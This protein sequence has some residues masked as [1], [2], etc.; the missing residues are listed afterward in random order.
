MPSA[1]RIRWRR[2][3]EGFLFISPWLIGFLAFTLGPMIASAAISLTNYDILSPLL[4]SRITV[5]GRAG[6]KSKS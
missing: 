1:H 2:H 6:K 3:V 4:M 5:D